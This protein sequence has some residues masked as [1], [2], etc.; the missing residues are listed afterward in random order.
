MSLDELLAY[1]QETEKWFVSQSA[2]GTHAAVDS[3]R[4]LQ[5]AIERIGGAKLALLKHGLLDE[6]A[7]MRLATTA[8]NGGVPNDAW[9]KLLAR[10]GSVMKTCIVRAGG[11]FPVPEMS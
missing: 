3:S 1:L 6:I 5:D 8:L 11:C 9:R 4:R 10:L 2:S 7:L